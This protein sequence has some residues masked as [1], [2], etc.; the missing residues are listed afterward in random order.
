M[1]PDL[2]E[3][4]FRQRASE[5]ELQAAER[6]ERLLAEAHASLKANH[7]DPH[8]YIA[9]AR[10]C[11][12]IGRL[13]ETLEILRQGIGLCA[14]SVP[15]YEY[16]IERLEKCNRTEEAIAAAREAALLF[17]DEL[18]FRLREALLLPI[19]YDTPEQVDCYR[20]RFTEA[21]TESYGR[22]R[23]IR[24]WSG[25]AR[26]RPSDDTATSICLTRDRTIANCR[27]STAL[28]YRE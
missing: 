3:T 7:R 28:G 17:P 12:Q 10:T 8:C 16:Y 6:R 5:A 20:R 21:C 25:G 1:P 27:R 19:L 11:K 13:H 14:P 23:W 2:M 9:A 15:L 22:C 26:A 24:P 18:I 4:L